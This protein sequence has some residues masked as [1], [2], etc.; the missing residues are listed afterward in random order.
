MSELEIPEDRVLRRWKDRLE[1]AAENPSNPL[2]T[3]LP[4]VLRT[5][6]CVVS[7]VDVL[8]ILDRR[9]QSRIG[10]QFSTACRH[11]RDLIAE[12]IDRELG[13]GK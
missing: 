1:V 6:D 9:A 12:E 13:G 11:A 4:G 7:P 3:C 2:N 10:S 5:V 8:M